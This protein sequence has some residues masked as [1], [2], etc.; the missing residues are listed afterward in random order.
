[1][2]L[3]PSPLRRRA[4]KTIGSCSAVDD[5]HRHLLDIDRLWNKFFFKYYIIFLEISNVIKL[6]GPRWWRKDVPEL[7]VT[8]PA[9]PTLASVYEENCP[10]CP[11]QQCSR[12]LSLSSLDRVDPASWTSQSGEMLAQLD[13][14][15]DHTGSLVGLLFSNYHEI[16]V[17]VVSNFNTVSHISVFQKILL[18]Q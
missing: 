12:M 9:E 15:A 2:T 16:F 1:M 18:S 11:S 13:G 14:W 4:K 17:A 6:F 8:L 10:L 5:F 3:A 7:R